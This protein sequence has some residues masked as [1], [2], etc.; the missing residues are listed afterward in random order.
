MCDSPPTK[1]LRRSSNADSDKENVP[2]SDDSERARKRKI[3][4]RHTDGHVYLNELPYELAE[5]IFDQVSLMDLCQLSFVSQVMRDNVRRYIFYRHRY[6]NAHML[7]CGR[8]GRV[9]VKD[10]ALFMSCF[11]SLLRS[12]YIPMQLF[13]P[14]AECKLYQIVARKCPNYRTLTIAR[15]QRGERS[16]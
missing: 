14:A 9:T 1:R 13:E 12:V 4:I 11:G 15:P 2:P 6:F 8:T 16:T 7:R 5:D 3:P 10:V